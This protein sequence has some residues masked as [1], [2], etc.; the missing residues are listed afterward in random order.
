MAIKATRTLLYNPA[1]I[2]AWYLSL[3][4]CN[5]DEGMESF[6]KSGQASTVYQAIV[7]ARTMGLDRNF[8]QKLFEIDLLCHRFFTALS[9]VSNEELA[10]RLV[11]VQG[12]L[13]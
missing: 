3:A 10:T 1:A 2:R 12:V 5:L 6:R 11:I 4:S 8:A 7:L 9:L 13:P